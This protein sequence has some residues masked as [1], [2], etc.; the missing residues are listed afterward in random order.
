VCSNHFRKEDY[1][2][3]NPVRKLLGQNAVPSVFDWSAERAPR[4]AL[5]RKIITSSETQTQD[6]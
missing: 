2:S 3:W 5:K 6:R 4:R 1:K